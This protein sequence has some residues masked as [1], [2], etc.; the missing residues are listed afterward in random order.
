[1]SMATVAMANGIKANLLRRWVRAAETRPGA[2]LPNAQ[3]A[4]K[5]GVT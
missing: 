5:R 2:D 1:M 4:P 3:P